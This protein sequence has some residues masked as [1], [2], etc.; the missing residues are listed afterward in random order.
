MDDVDSRP[1]EKPLPSEESRRPS[2]AE[3][4]VDSAMSIAQKVS[5]IVLING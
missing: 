3:G 4:Q 5:M 2:V 1:A